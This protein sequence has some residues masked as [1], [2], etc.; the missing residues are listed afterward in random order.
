MDPKATL[1]ELLTHLGIS[2][3]ITE[4]PEDDQVMLDIQTDDSSRLIGR[5]GQTLAE[6]QFLLNRLVFKND[7]KVP[8]IILDVGGYRRQIRDLLTKRANEAAEKVRRWGDIVEMEPMNAY[9]R[10]IVHQTLK[11]DPDVE[12]HSV[13]VDGSDKKVVL[14]RP[15]RH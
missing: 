9:D 3:T 7:S 13:E 6:L 5:S 1:H 15:R 12:T 4:Y 8:R 10:R 14:I 2:A 11:D